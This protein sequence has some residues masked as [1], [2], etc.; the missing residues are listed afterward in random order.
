MNWRWKEEY[1]DLILV[2]TGLLI[3]FSY[4]LF[5]L[6]RYLRFPHT[7][8]MGCEDHYKRVWVEKT[9]QLDA[10]DRGT[11]ISVINSNIIASTNMTS[12]SLVLSS[13]IGTWIGSSS[14]K[15]ILSSSVIYGDTR[16]T[17][18]SYK[19]ISLLSCFLVAFASFVQMLRN[20]T[21]AAFL[22]SMPHCEIPASYVQKAVIKG[23]NYWVIG[24]RA[25]YF[26]T[27]LIMWIFG[28]ISMFISSVIMVA[29]LRNLDTTSTEP[30]LFQSRFRHQNCL[31]VGEELVTVNRAFGHQERTM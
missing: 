4:H 17:I 3:M 13:L 19:Y 24:L 9:M 21:L 16:M 10:K 22:I 6:Y 5:L 1:L 2:P 8:V 23:S 29:V 26:A 28:P 11:A 31:M 15:S 18:T 30:Y 20:Y 12:V 25:L 27:T 14:G 7:T